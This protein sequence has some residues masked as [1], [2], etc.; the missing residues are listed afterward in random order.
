MIIAPIIFLVLLYALLCVCLTSLMASK[1]SSRFLKQ[2]A[3]ILLSALI[4]P[5]LLLMLFF[6]PSVMSLE[7]VFFIMVLLV[8]P[9]VIRL[10]R[11]SMYIQRMAIRDGEVH[12]DY[13]TDFLQRKN[14]RISMHD[15]RSVK[16]DHIRYL[17]DYPVRVQLELRN[18]SSVKL[19]M[20]DGEQLQLQED[21]I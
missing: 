8:G 17:T 9:A 12:I 10:L 13:L 6:G 21:S 11:E 16:V 1:A 5:V 2:E 20:I 4:P 15:I 3:K 7:G 18:G 14:L 19:L